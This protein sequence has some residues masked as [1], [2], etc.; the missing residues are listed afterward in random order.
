VLSHSP[1]AGFAHRNEVEVIWRSFELAPD[2]PK[3]HSGTLLEL[4]SAKYAVTLERATEMNV[5]VS[6]I[7]REAILGG[8]SVSPKQG[9]I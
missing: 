5:R 7:A 2:S 1:L 9:R 6:D 4:L 3:R 8:V